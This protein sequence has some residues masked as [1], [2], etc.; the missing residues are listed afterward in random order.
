MFMEKAIELAKQI[1]KDV[2]VSAIIVKDGEI[3]LSSTKD[4]VFT[5][6]LKLPLFK[7]V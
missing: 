5:V 7:E 1:E 2:P 4:N 3:S 6:T